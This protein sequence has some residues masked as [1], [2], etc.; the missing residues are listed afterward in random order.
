ML[1]PQGVNLTRIW[2][3]TVVRTLQRN[4]GNDA[5]IQAL[6]SS[7]YPS[8]IHSV[9]PTSPVASKNIPS[10]F[11]GSTVHPLI[12]HVRPTDIRGYH[13]TSYQATCLVG[14]LEGYSMTSTF[15][16]LSF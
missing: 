10:E 3:S 1:W 8:D 7:V 13:H 12:S 11:T 14:S 6:V 15:V 2:R 5:G 9:K 16:T 4:G